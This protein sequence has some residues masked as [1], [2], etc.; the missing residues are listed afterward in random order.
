VAELPDL[1][2]PRSDGFWRVG[3]HT[4]CQPPDNWTIATEDV[5][6]AVPV[7]KRPAVKEG[8]IPCEQAKGIAE[9]KY[10]QLVSKKNGSNKDDVDLAM[11]KADGPAYQCD[12]VEITIEFLNPF[13]VSL[14]NGY[15]T[16]CGVHPDGRVDYGVWRLD[17]LDQPGVSLS[18]IFGEKAADAYVSLAKQALVDNANDPFQSD[19]G[20]TKPPK[21][22]RTDQ[23]LEELSMGDSGC[24]PGDVNDREWYISRHE[25]RWIE[26]GGIFTHRLCGVVEFPLRSKMFTWSVIDKS[27]PLDMKWLRSLLPNARDA[28]WSPRKDLL[29]VLTK[30][31]SL[32]VFKPVGEKIGRP[33]LTLPLTQQEVPVMA[34]WAL[35]AGVERWTRELTTLQHRGFPELQLQQKIGK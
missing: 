5:L 10:R 6:I 2:V 29:V 33:L 9:E 7:S 35:G 27:V 22:Y 26:Q 23:S 18:S 15:E 32:S 13:Y 19:V 28:F 4:Y 1:V 11:A 25:G 34:E 16:L 20:R 3:V 31:D 21:T 24:F 30:N 14:S 17:S 12:S 8:L